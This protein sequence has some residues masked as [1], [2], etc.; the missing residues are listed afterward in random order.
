M[1]PTKP[2][3]HKPMLAEWTSEI[4]SLSLLS[5]D[6]VPLDI[7]LA[8]LMFD[9]SPL[10]VDKVMAR[11]SNNNARKM[12]GHGQQ[13]HHCPIECNTYEGELLFQPFSQHRLTRTH[14]GWSH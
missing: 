2:R 8:D 6:A 13:V 4:L 9:L 3:P 1:T 7:A 5:F 11:S 12:L 14:L 10:L